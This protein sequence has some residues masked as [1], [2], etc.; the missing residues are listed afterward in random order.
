MNESIV[1]RFWFP[2]EDDIGVDEAGFLLDPEHD[3]FKH[4]NSSAVCLSDLRNAPCLVLLGEAGL[5]KSTDL[6][7]EH[8]A[9]ALGCIDPHCRS[10][11]RRE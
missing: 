5:G 11:P 8:R 10:R 4:V 2:R 3:F 7:A 9:G 1:K 6:E